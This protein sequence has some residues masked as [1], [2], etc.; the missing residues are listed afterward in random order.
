MTR[1][2][3]FLKLPVLALLG[4]VTAENS[5]YDMRI[6]RSFIKKV[7]DKNFNEVLNNIEDKFISELPL[8]SLGAD[9]KQL[10]MRIMP[11]DGKYWDDI[12]SELFFDQGQIVMEINNL[13][14]AG[15]GEITDSAGNSGVLAL[16]APLEFCQLV[17][18][19]D[20]VVNDEGSLLPKI[21]VS[22]VAF[23][24]KKDA[25]SISIDGN[26]P[27]Y[28]T[29]QFKEGVKKWM[30]DSIRAREGDFK[31]ALQVAEKQVMSSF[32]FKKNLAFGKA[33]SSSLAE[34]MKLQGDHVMLSWLT[35]YEGKDL[36]NVAKKLRKIKPKFEEHK[37]FQKD[38]QVVL[39]ENY[40]NYVLFTLLYEDKPISVTDLLLDRLP[41]TFM[42]AGAAIKAVMNTNVFG[43]VF[44]ELVREFGNGKRLDLR[45]GMNKEY[46]SKGH[47]RDDRVS[48]V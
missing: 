34:S 46:L 29:S 28:E 44:P 41:E 19:L 1:F 7:A 6:H 8:A 11:Q 42:G 30:K 32:K 40:I 37:N 2:P 26:L 17:M 5:Q 33:A 13:S 12:E 38:I 47:L 35:E 27:V 24:L 10:H 14:Y 39:D 20:Q 48:S 21:T 15:H 4:Y 16:H 23:Q 9:V 31:Q 22:D 45:C 36:A 18:S 3:A 25:F 43:L